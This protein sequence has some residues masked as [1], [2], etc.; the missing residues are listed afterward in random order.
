[1]PDDEQ[2]DADEH[3]PRGRDS[4]RAGETEERA[5]LIPDATV[6][7]ER[8][9][10]L[11]SQIRGALDAAARAGEHREF[12]IGRTAAW[13][14]QIIVAGLVVLALLDWLLEAPTDSLLVK[15]AFAAVL[16]LSALTAFVVSHGD[17]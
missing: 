9:E 16:Q 10:K 7:L 14:L 12:S 11:L 8:M 3:Q 15:L 13:V 17:S 6:T 2:S 5:D 1:M 4:G